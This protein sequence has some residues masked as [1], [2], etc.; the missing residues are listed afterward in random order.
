MSN[1]PFKMKGW[2]PFTDK[3]SRKAKRKFKKETVVIDGKT[4]NKKE[5]EEKRRQEAEKKLAGS[6][7][8]Q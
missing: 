4:Y 3:E 8:S 5:L 2:S 7:Y 1:T 6:K